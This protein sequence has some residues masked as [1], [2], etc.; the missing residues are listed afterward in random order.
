MS[1]D[2]SNGE[3]G[4]YKG[5]VYGALLGLGLAW[6]INTKEGKKFKKQINAKS[7]EFLDKTKERIETALEDNFV[8]NNQTSGGIEEKTEAIKKRFFGDYY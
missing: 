3:D 2:K 5:L 8:E 4:F 7:E 6:F 1:S